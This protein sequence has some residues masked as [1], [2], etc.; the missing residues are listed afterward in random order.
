MLRP[1]GSDF[2]ASLPQRQTPARPA[3]ARRRPA[4]R[5]CR[6]YVPRGSEPILVHVLVCVGIPTQCRSGS[7]IGCALPRAAFCRAVKSKSVF[8]TPSAETIDRIDSNASVAAA[9]TAGYAFESKLTELRRQYV[10][11]ESRLHAEYLA[12]LAAL[13]SDEGTEE[14]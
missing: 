11:Q 9:R 7:G 2:E 6:V 5:I 12:E 1:A 4:Q 10:T 8:G 13:G 3:T 14:G